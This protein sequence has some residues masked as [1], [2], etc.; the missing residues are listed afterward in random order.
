MAHGIDFA[1]VFVGPALWSPT[2]Q[3][4]QIT[5]SKSTSLYNLVLSIQNFIF[6][7]INSFGVDHVYRSIWQ[8][9]LARD[10]SAWAENW[11]A[12]ARMA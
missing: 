11:E 12:V 10:T 4:G 2:F 1:L 7:L 9:I 5:G 8:T 3:E 6:Q